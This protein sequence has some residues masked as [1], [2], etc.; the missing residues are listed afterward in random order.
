VGN[1]LV[2]GGIMKKILCRHKDE[3]MFELLGF[4]IVT[5]DYGHKVAVNWLL[6]KR[7][8]IIHKKYLYILDE[9]E[10]NGYK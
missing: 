9:G 5:E 3:V 6:N 4:G 2:Y 10:Q 1:P 8:H 7:S